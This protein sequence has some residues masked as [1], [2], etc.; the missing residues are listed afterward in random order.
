[1]TATETQFKVTDETYLAGLNAIEE[2]RSARGCTGMTHRVEL[3]QRHAPMLVALM[4]AKWPKRM[5]R[6]KSVFDVAAFEIAMNRTGVRPT[7]GY[8]PRG[9]ASAGNGNREDCGS[10]PQ[11]RLARG[12][13]SM[14]DDYDI[15]DLRCPACDNPVTHSRD[16]F[17][18]DQSNEE[19]YCCDD[20]CVG[21]RALHPWRRHGPVPRVCRNGRPAVVS[22]VR[23]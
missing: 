1:M 21:R 14:E 13:R 8:L 3:R 23:R 10:N 2:I 11:P 20:L 19:V 12:K 18:C 16:C 17:D 4:K 6:E 9:S 15:D 7:A 5:E 22:E